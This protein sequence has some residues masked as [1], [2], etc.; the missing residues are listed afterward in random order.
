M[1]VHKHKDKMYEKEQN[2]YKAQARRLELRYKLTKLTNSVGL[3]GPVW[4]KLFGVILLHFL[5]Y[6]FRM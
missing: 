6:M 3:L 1:Y 5:L 4:C 2:S